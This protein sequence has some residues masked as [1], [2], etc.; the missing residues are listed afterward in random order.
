MSPQQIAEY[1]KETRSIRGWFWPAAAYLF[2]L[3]EDHQNRCS[4]SGGFFEIG[5][6][7]GKSTHLLAR[8]ARERGQT[9]GVCDLFGTDDESHARAG[10]GF[11]STFQSHL[12]GAFDSLGFLRVFIKPSNRLTTA[13]TTTDC[14]FFHID[15]DHEAASVANDL[16]VA[17]RAVNERGVVIV[18]DIY[19]FA[20]PGVAEGFFQFMASRPGEL[21]PIAMGF[22]KLVLCRPAA[23][24]M[25]ESLFDDAAAPWRF[26]PRG[27][28][29]LKT[30]DLCG[31]KT[32]V[33]HVPSYRSPD[34][35]RTTLTMLYQHAPRLSDRV[36][37]LVRY[38]ARAGT[39][40]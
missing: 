32:R 28:T 37:R 3:I 34:P 20:W 10:G 29:S 7:H 26:I 9:L 40:S 33:F 30:L 14:R 22:N 24:A 36:S 12:S 18:D 8:M 1:L 31:W 19:N 38:H 4:V 21:A 16:A 27:P 11:Y 23:R 39:A 17:A 13:D 35:L 5:V 2:G 25:Y 15:G 6:F